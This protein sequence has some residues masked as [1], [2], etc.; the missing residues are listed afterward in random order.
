M[1]GLWEMGIVGWC[2]NMFFN[3]FSSV[4]WSPYLYIYNYIYIE[5]GNIQLIISE[6]LV[7]GIFCHKRDC[8]NNQLTTFARYWRSA[9][10]SW[11]D[12]MKSACW[13]YCEVPQPQG[14]MQ[15]LYH[16]LALAPTA[17]RKSDQ[18]T[19]TKPDSL[20]QTRRVNKSILCNCARLRNIDWC[21]RAAYDYDRAKSSGPSIPKRRAESPKSAPPV[22]MKR[23]P[24]KPP[25]QEE[26]QEAA[27]TDLM[28]FG[29]YSYKTYEEV[30]TTER[31]YAEWLKQT[32]RRSTY[33]PLRRY[34]RSGPRQWQHRSMSIRAVAQ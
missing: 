10:M 11:G 12:L 20:I 34:L 4:Q 5:V 25:A 21:K 15:C 18:H 14:S 17:T 24:A 28:G 29:R 30:L 22:K 27:G 8:C 13:T 19:A 9:I 3:V 7:L 26:E 31:D 16:T 33:W 6:S 32:A 1:T 2:F 23:P